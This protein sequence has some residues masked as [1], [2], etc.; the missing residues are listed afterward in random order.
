MHARSTDQTPP[1]YTRLAYTDYSVVL[2]FTHCNNI[3]LLTLRIHQ[4]HS[5][6]ISTSSVGGGGGSGIC[7]WWLQWHWLTF[8]HRKLL[9]I[10]QDDHWAWKVMEFR[11]TIF[12]AWIVMENSRGHGKSWNFMERSRI[13]SWSFYNCT[14]KFCNE[15]EQWVCRQFSL[16]QPA[17]TVT[18]NS[19]M[20]SY[21]MFR[22]FRE[23]CSANRSWNSLRLVLESRGKVMENDF[24]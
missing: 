24:R 15:C 3:N 16:L 21:V 9:T 11:M 7:G 22:L 23:K 12:Q 8:H 19:G 20:H 18:T 4:L 13:M 1:R 2:I 17:G 14:K 6:V 5:D 10:I